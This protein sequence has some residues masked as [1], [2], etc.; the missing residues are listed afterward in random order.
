MC[1]IVAV[2]SASVTAAS[3]DA[4][5]Q[6]ARWRGPDDRG[7]WIG[8]G[9]GLAHSRLAI[10]GERGTQPIENE[11]GT[12]RIVVN[13]ELYDFERIRADL[14]RRGHRFATDTDSEIA[15]HLYEE[16]GERCVEHLRGEF[17]FA[18]YDRRRRRLL[19]ARDRFGVKPL[20]FVRR[21]DDF[22]AASEAKQLFALGIRCAWDRDA[23]HHA[24]CHQYLPPDR[25]LFAG[26]RQLRPGCLLIVDDRG[27]RERK[28]WDLDL[29]RRRPDRA[30]DA[31][32]EL[33]E[34]LDEAVR[35]RLRADV[36]VACCLSGGV[37]SATVLAFAARHR[38][39]MESFGVSFDAADYDERAQATAV[40]GDL[41]SPYHP[42]RVTQDDLLLHLSDA[43]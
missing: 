14:E 5:L 16:Y 40:A 24:V 4:A 10:V 19:L 37:D 17:A 30:G 26:V 18:L 38:P 32:G 31:P 3:L 22:Y 12:V 15:L 9:I 8:D 2:R 11:D 27:V 23:F 21:G 43:V 34:H 13:G 41:G 1:G 42:V 35:L 28:Y 6:A 33:R 36:P 20:C 29:P 39:G 7:T 25:T